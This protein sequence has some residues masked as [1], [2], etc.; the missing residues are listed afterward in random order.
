M[1]DAWIGGGSAGGLWA[2]NDD[3]RIWVCCKGGGRGSV[4]DCECVPIMA[5]V[6]F[7]VSGMSPPPTSALPAP[8]PP[9]CLRIQ[10]QLWGWRW[11]LGV[12]H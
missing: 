7:V 4:C 2:D 12:V 5:M 1:S 11:G 8:V 6:S 3:S 9:L 10:Q